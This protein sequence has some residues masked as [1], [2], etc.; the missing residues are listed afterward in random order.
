[1]IS[2]METGRRRVPVGEDQAG[3][4]GWPLPIEAY[5]RNAPT[6][7]GVADARQP[8]RVSIT[9][10]VERDTAMP[11]VAIGG[12]PYHRDLLERAYRLKDDGDFELAVVAAQ[13][14]CE[15]LTEGCSQSCSRPRFR[16]ALLRR[17]SRVQV[18]RA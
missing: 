17:Q 11:M 14:A 10:A 8:Q 12:P 1:M 4:W 13:I 3:P 5:S 7:R 6:P 15:L 18:A 16:A 9:P 2:Q